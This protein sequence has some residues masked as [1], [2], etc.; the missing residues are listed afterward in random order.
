MSELFTKDIC[1]SIASVYLRRNF[2]I[3]STDLP[4]TAFKDAVLFKFYYH[5]VEILVR[6]LN[7]TTIA[8]INFKD[9]QSG[10]YYCDA[11]IISAELTTDIDESYKNFYRDAIKTYVDVLDMGRGMDVFINYKTLEF[12]RLLNKTQ[13]PLYA[14]LPSEFFKPT[15]MEIVKVKCLII[16]KECEIMILNNYE[17][18]LCS[19]DIFLMDGINKVFYNKLKFERKVI[20]K[21]Y[22]NEH[23]F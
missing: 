9:L 7:D 2:G 11:E 22:H 4:V 1:K 14:S 21:I 18:E 12:Y 8:V 17:D 5:P 13:Y 16:G 23:H 19:M 3:E 20:E 10:Y 15:R 6:L